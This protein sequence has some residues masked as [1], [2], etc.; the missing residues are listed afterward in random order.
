M[1]RFS[2]SLSPNGF[3]ILLNIWSPMRGAGIKIEYIA[4]DY[5]EVKVGLK[6][7]WFNQNYVG[8]HFGGSIYAMTDPFF[9]LMLIKNLGSG[10][11]VWDKAATI[12]FKK[13]G[14]GKITAHFAFSA[15]EIV[16][17]KQQADTNGKYI[18]DRPVDVINEQGEVVASIV[19]TLYVRNKS[20]DKN[21]EIK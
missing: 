3:R 13:P 14:K 10:Y 9:M 18:F 15:E 4:P 7:Q 16:A 6:L 11:I 1:R 17:I 8:T 2:A 5:R 20:F 19:K 21:G 12:E